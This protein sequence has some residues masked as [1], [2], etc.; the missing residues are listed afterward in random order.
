MTTWRRDGSPTSASPPAKACGHCGAHL[1]DTHLEE[2]ALCSQCA[3]TFDEGGRFKLVTRCD[4]CFARVLADCVPD[5]GPAPVLMDPH[6]PTGIDVS[7]PYFVVTFN[8]ETDVVFE[9]DDCRCCHAC[10]ESLDPCEPSVSQEEP[11]LYDLEMRL[12]R[13]ETKGFHLSCLPEEIREELKTQ[14]EALPRIPCAQCGTSE[15]SDPRR[16]IWKVREPWRA[17]HYLCPTCINRADFLIR[18]RENCLFQPPWHLPQ[19]AAAANARCFPNE[20][21]L[22]HPDDVIDGYAIFDHEGQLGHFLS[23]SECGHDC[24][25]HRHPSSFK[26][27][28]VAS[29]A[30]CTGDPPLWERWIVRGDEIRLCSPCSASWQRSGFQLAWRCSRCCSTT[31]CSTRF[32]AAPPGR[33]PSRPDGLYQRTPFFWMAEEPDCCTACTKLVA[34]AALTPVESA[35]LPRKRGWWSRLFQRSA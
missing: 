22:S 10:W 13:A 16:A 17:V 35:L 34:A 18:C 27:L 1:R 25:P 2:P 7:G 30:T 33:N 32:G 5:I 21:D 11:W 26:R 19:L 24:A 20:L 4:T 6:S 8:P 12:P 14:W 29:C 28:R 3:R 9:C 15:G 31:F 23:L